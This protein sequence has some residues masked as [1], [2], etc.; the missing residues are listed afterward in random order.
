MWPCARLGEK[1]LIA[2]VFD[3]TGLENPRNPCIFAM[4]DNLT[5]LIDRLMR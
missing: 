2:G 3:D 1:Q 5:C 4:R